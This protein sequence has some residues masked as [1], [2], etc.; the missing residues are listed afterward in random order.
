M[1]DN[2]K[3]ILRELKKESFQWAGEFMQAV[4]AHLGA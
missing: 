3:K 4:K 1:T 2:I